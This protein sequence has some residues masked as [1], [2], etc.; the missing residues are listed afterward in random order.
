MFPYRSCLELLAK[1]LRFFLFERENFG[2]QKGVISQ[3]RWFILCIMIRSLSQM[4]L[5]ANHCKLICKIL[6]L[7]RIKLKCG[8]LTV[9]ENDVNGQS[10]ENVNRLSLTNLLSC[11]FLHIM[12][13][14][15][16]FLAHTPKFTKN[17]NHFKIPFS[18]HWITPVF[19]SY[20]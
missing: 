16:T 4:S 19:H 3:R 18:V 7:P 5:V 12:I 15:V 1:I 8:L 9:A 14:L 11:L 10:S 20:Q 13:F 2:V 6:Y 17:F